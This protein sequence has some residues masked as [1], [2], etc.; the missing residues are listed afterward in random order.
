MAIYIKAFVLLPLLFVSSY[1]RNKHIDLGFDDA[2]DSSVGVNVDPSPDGFLEFLDGKKKKNKKSKKKNKKNELIFP[3]FPF[4]FPFHG[5][6][7]NQQDQPAPLEPAVEEK[8]NGIPKPDF[9][10][11]NRGAWMIHS[12]NAGVAAMHIQLMPNNK[13][14]WFDTTNLGPSAIQNN[15]PFCK[16]VPEKPGE[17]DCWSHGVQYDVES[18]QVRTLKVCYLLILISVSNFTKIL[19]T[20]ACKHYVKIRTHE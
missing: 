19:C 16:L 13:A 4:P 10:T 6:H 18:G 1:A 11:E 7:E 8:K 15:P 5:E 9:E 17:T 12:P 3:Q 2:D 20:H 14:V